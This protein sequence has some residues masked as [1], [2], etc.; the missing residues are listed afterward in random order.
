MPRT[1]TAI[2]HLLLR[3]GVA[4]AFLYPPIDALSDPD[5]WIGYF[6]RFIMSLPVDPLLILHSF[7]ALEVL[8][9]IWILSG[10]KIRIPAVL[11]AAIL[12]AIVLFNGAQF[13]ILFRDVSI[14]LAALALAFL[15]RQRPSAASHA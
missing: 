15:P 5:S 7:G 12:A 14:A 4:F 3:I 13:A 11:A 6:P 2:G 8:L 9:A 10:W 1:P